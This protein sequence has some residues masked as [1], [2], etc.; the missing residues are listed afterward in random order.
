MCDKRTPPI[1]RSIGSYTPSPE[2]IWTDD[3]E[4]DTEAAILMT[5]LILS[6]YDRVRNPEIVAE[7][8][9]E[10]RILRDRHFEEI[11]DL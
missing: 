9:E 7:L 8:E 3:L 4:L 11:F 1:P 6:T 2:E 10:L 5:E